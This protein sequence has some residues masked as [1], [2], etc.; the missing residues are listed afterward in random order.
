M[1]TELFRLLEVPASVAG[2]RLDRFLSRWFSTW[3]RSALA[4]GARAGL[5]TDEHDVRLRPAHIVRAGE[6]LRLYLPGIAPGAPAPTFPPILHEDDRVVVLDKPAGMLTHPAGND[7]T[8]AVVSLAKQRW[9]EADLVHRI[10]RDTSGV[11]VLAKDRDANR[12]LKAAFHDGAVKK[13]Y[14]AICR[15]HI[16]W[17]EAVFDG[18]IGPATGPIRIQMAVRPDGQDA[19]TEV[20]VLRRQTGLTWVE[21]RIHTGRTHQI[22]VHLA[23]AGFS[24][25]GDRMYGVAPEVFLALWD[26]GPEADAIA[27]SGAPRQALHARQ[28]VVPH[29]DVGTI[30]VEAPI[31]ADLLRWWEHPERLPF[32]SETPQHEPPEHHEQ[33]GDHK[34]RMPDTAEAGGSVPGRA[35]EQ[36]D[37]EPAHVAGGVDE[38]EDEREHE[39]E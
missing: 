6:R 36:P 19:L 30:T 4:R 21:C 8:W 35:E 26:G 10:D 37:H 17:D 39:V 28:V 1:G 11:L 32:D 12:I 22:R 31:P 13:V 24:L 25:L 16:P 2:M 7:F 18:P 3:S 14:H 38:R 9:P 5:V 33:A 27:A 20:R 29:P 15:G 23:H 34:E